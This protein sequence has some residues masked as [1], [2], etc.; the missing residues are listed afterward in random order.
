MK[1]KYSSLNKSSSIRIVSFVLTSLVSAS[2]FAV[3]STFDT[4]FDGWTSTTGVSWQGSGGN[5][6]GY[7]QFVDAGPAN[8]GQIISPAA[9]NGDWL[10]TYGATGSFSLDYKLFAAGS[11]Q[12]FPM[13]VQI[14]GSGGVIS[15]NLPGNYA[16]P[17]GWTSYSNTLQAGNWNLDSGTFTGCLTN[18]TEV[19]VFMPCSSDAN[20]ITGVDNIKVAAVPEPATI[21]ALM[22]GL[23][24]VLKSRRKNIAG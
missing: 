9:F 23:G 21:L 3:I 13:F 15:Q 20:E 8:G 11:F 7:L 1:Y 22:A 19:R 14:T 17:F 16:S 4:G 12:L 2:S 5:P 24:G 6:G 10:S 18:V